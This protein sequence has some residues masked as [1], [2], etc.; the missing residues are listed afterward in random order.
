MKTIKIALMSLSISGLI[1]TTSAEAKRDHMDWDRGHGQWNKEDKMDKRHKDNDHKNKIDENV[2]EQVQTVLTKDSIAPLLEDVQSDRNAIKDLREAYKFFKEEI[3]MDNQEKM[4][5]LKVATS[6]A[7][8]AEILAEIAANNAALQA[9]K[10]QTK[11]QIKDIREEFVPAKKELIET[12][13]TEADLNN[14]EVRQ[15]LRE[16]EILGPM[17][18]DN[19][20]ATSKTEVLETAEIPPVAVPGEVVLV[21][22]LEPITAP[23]PEPEVMLIPETEPAPPAELDPVIIPESE[24][25]PSPMEELTAETELI[26]DSTK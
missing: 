21:A 25:L 5:T 18:L 12:I 4:N 10:E 2:V 23:I 15:A 16:L 20:S 7:E 13:A 9:M 3:Q 11:E 8:R 24:I 14:K 17:K 6:D 26:P 1:M 22:E 19:P